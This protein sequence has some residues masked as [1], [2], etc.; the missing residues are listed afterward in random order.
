MKNKLKYLTCLVSLIIIVTSSFAG[1]DLTIQSAE[2]LLIPPK[3]NIELE[4]ALEDAVGEKVILRSPNG[5]NSEYKNAISMYDIDGDLTD[6]AVVFYS[7]ANNSDSIHLNVLK[8]TDDKWKS[9]AD[10][11]NTAGELNTLSFIKLIEKSKTTEIIVT[12]KYLDNNILSVYKYISE[13]SENKNAKIKLMCNEY[14]NTMKMLDVEQDGKLDFLTIGFS[15]NAL[16]STPLAK[17]I[18]VN[19]DNTVSNENFISLNKEIS[20]F[21]SVQVIPADEKMPLRVLIDYRMKDNY[22]LT[23]IL[24]WDKSSK[25][26][27]TLVDNPITKKAISTQRLVNITCTDVNG[28]DIADIP[29]QVPIVASALVKKGVVHASLSYTSWARINNEQGKLLLSNL[30]INRYYF[31]EK[32]YLDIDNKWLGLF[33]VINKSDESLWEIL[34]HSVDESAEVKQQTLAFVKIIKTDDLEKYTMTGYFPIYANYTDKAAC[35]YK[36]TEYGE[37]FGI[38]PSNFVSIQ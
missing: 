33:T 21:Q 8:K 14:F 16:N 22:Y 9:I 17:V 7:L 3:S 1:C 11:D 6:E 4:N 26:L 34:S 5:Q 23:T 12:W 20:E 32:G 38:M 37:D 13:D 35:V 2:K 28:D 27:K 19:D 10:F 31:T 25:S 18:K 30:D 15:E 29:V 36:I 24:Y